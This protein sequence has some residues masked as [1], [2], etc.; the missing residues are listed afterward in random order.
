[1]RWWLVCWYA[2]HQR[3]EIEFVALFGWILATS[4]LYAAAHVLVPDTLRGSGDSLPRLQPIR[5]AFYLCLGTQFLLGATVTLTTGPGSYPNLFPN[6]GALPFSQRAA[7]YDRSVRPS[8][9][10]T[11]YALARLGNRSDPKLSKAAQSM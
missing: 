9:V 6:L 5:A 1:M 7:L 3:A 2:L 11:P 10:H 8:R 4:S